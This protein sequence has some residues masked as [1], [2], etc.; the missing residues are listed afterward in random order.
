MRLLPVFIS[1]LILVGCVSF[2]AGSH[3]QAKVVETNK[4][5]QPQWVALAP[6]VL[7][8]NGG[9]YRFVELQNN[10]KDLPLGLKQAQIG[11]LSHRFDNSRF[12]SYLYCVQFNCT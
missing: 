10:F 5:S 3:D 6:G 11:A 1:F 2:D 9:S 4:E 7:H 12:G 8:L